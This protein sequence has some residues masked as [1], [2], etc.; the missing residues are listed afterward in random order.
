M[1][2]MGEGSVRGGSSFKDIE[3]V[4]ERFRVFRGGASAVK[5]G[6][7]SFSSNE[8]IELSSRTVS[9]VSSASFA[10]P[11]SF[12]DWFFSTTSRLMRSVA[13]IPVF[14]L[15]GTSRASHDTGGCL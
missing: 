7:A 12:R 8:G 2:E 14:R 11:P 5:L 13:T 1:V 9:E 15:H 3:G 10:L 6:V 4:V